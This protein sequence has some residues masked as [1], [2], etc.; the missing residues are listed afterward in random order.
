MR[1]A[2]A[3][4]P[5][6]P[7]VI[8]ARAGANREPAAPVRAFITAT[9]VKLGIHGRA[10]DPSVTTVAADTRSE[11][12][13]VLESARAPAGVWAIMPATPPMDITSPMDACSQCWIVSR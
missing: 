12:L 8:A 10:N 13:A 7:R 1:R 4:G 2:K 9:A 6:I 11:R 5:T 3:F